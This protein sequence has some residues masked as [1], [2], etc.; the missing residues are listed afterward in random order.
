MGSERRCPRCG[1]PATVE[2]E[3][4][5]RSDRT[6]SRSLLCTLCGAEF[7]ARVMSGRAA[8]P[9]EAP[10]GRG[11]RLAWIPALLLAAW[12]A[13]RLLPYGGR[14]G[15][16]RTVATV[17]EGFRS[18][19]WAGALTLVALLLLVRRGGTR[20]AIRISHPTLA[21]DVHIREEGV[22]TLAVVLS[23]TRGG[24]ATD[25]VVARRP[26]EEE[27][28]YRRLSELA[29][30]SVA[31]TP[32]GVGSPGSREARELR[33]E[34]RR[35]IHSLGVVAGEVLLGD[36]GG[37]REQLFDLPGDH[38][39]LRIQPGLARVP[40]ELVVERPGAQ[41]LWQR[42]HVA[43]QVR[44]EADAAAP[45]PRGQGPLRVLLLANLEVDD[46][47]R[48]LPAAEAEAMELLEIAAREPGRMRVVRRTPRSAEELRAFTAEGFDVVHFAGHTAAGDASG[49][50]V[51][52]G[53]AAVD[54]ASVLADAG[55]VPV[56][57]FANACR[58]G[59]GV[60]AAPWGANAGARLL[61]AGVAAYVGTI[62]ELDDAGSAD[63]ARVFYRSI[64]S[65]ATAGEAMTAARAALTE[66]R[67]FTWANYALYGDPT[68][69]L[70]AD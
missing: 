35:E 15:L 58:S 9:C 6:V 48:A 23:A 11:R 7:S 24:T 66:L 16:Y 14:A 3:I 19:I 27:R 2:K 65:G 45:R 22:G 54:P 17:L 28:I 31:F 40:W 1:G 12:L 39:L 60:S 21:P 68:L 43:R 25:F 61:R 69:R 37:A 38:L 56:V 67:P 33:A 49:G 62:W 44:D 47:G 41:F 8:P 36:D 5:T 59:P 53:G 63:F 32:D 70:V 50:W 29:A 42:Y 13:L 4:W 64:L 30:R 55:T 34:V 10:A 20:R 51:V 57:V 18:P 46:P 26:D 52:R